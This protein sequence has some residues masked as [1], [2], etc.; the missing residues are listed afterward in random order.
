[1]NSQMYPPLII[2]HRGV[3]SRA[4][5]NTLPALAAAV[6]KSQPRLDAVEIDIHSTADGEIVLHHNP[7]TPAGTV[8]AN[9]TL[10]ELSREI[11]PD[12]STMP[13]LSAALDALG[14]LAVYV[15]AKGVAPDADA[16]LLR[17]LRVGPNPDRYQIH[18]FDHRVIARIGA[19]ASDFGLGVLSCSYPLQPERQAI[20]AGARTLWQQWQLI[21][22]EL[23]ERCR[24][25]GID[26]IAWTVP[27]G[28]MAEVAAMG[29]AGICTDV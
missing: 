2:G 14:G 10:A 11:L 20:D 3:T 23:M 26:V 22:L 7:T 13:T 28:R 25:H 24:R 21:D 5:E 8:I 9:A 1:M 27:A 12:G 16:E 18:G 15:E 29:V 6:E 17:V 19:R 4:L